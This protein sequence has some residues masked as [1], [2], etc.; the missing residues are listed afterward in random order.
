MRHC[1]LATIVAGL[2]AVGTSMAA[3]AAEPDRLERN[4]DWTAFALKR[5]GGKVCYM[6]SSPKKSEGD[7]TSRGDIFTLVTN[8]AA[9][10]IRG[11]V[12]VIAGY[13]YRADSQVTLQIGGA[14][15]ELF[16]SGDR[17]WTRGPEDDRPLVDAMI[18]G[19]DMVVKGYSSRGTLTT[20]TYSLSGFTATK[21]AIDR[22]C[23]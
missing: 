1:I 3:S 8:D 17:A 6:V 9:A 7:Y 12:S 4:G 16:T 5:D 15:F 13:S 23:P 2:M 11:E 22:A 19:S 10:G 18:K 21:K 14:G 20:D